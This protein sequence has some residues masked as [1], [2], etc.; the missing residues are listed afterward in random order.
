MEMHQLSVNVRCQREGEG[1]RPGVKAFLQSIDFI[2]FMKGV[3]EVNAS[4]Y[5]G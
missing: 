3:T 1:D 2:K 5:E 4:Q